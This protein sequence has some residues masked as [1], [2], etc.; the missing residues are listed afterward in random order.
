MAK[1]LVTG[2]E[3]Q[4]GQ[5]FQW[6][7]GEFPQHQFY[8]VNQAKVDINHP[9]TLLDN[10]KKTPFDLILNCAAYTQV[11]LAETETKQAQESN[12]QGVKN[13]AAFAENKKVKLINFSTDFI[14]D[15]TLERLYHENDRPQPLN[16]YGKTKLAGEHALKNTKCIHTTFRIS[17]LFSPFGKNFVKT[18]LKAA[19]SKETLQVVND[20]WGEPTYGLDLVRGVLECIDHPNLFRYKTYH[21][22]QGPKTNWYKLAAKVVNLSGGNCLVTPVSNLLNPT[23]AK[24]PFHAVLDTKRIEKTLALPIPGWENALKD[25]IT[26]IVTNENI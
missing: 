24:R 18:I 23:A 5:C 19:Q 7:A 6:V 20:L 10:Y 17:W 21:Y 16:N 9:Q 12:V 3:G 13:L 26:K 25:C 2:A 4:L 8:F 15:G 11:D 22:A 1:V 14:F